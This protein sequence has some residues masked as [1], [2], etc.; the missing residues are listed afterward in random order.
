MAFYLTFDTPLEALDEGIQPLIRALRK[1]GQRT[2]VSCSGLFSDHPYANHTSTYVGI[3]PRDAQSA[4]H[5]KDAVIHIGGFYI[6]RK[7]FYIEEDEEQVD[8]ALYINPGSYSYDDDDMNRMG[9]AYFL[10]RFTALQRGEIEPL[11]EQELWARSQ[12]QET[13]FSDLLQANMKKIIKV[14]IRDDSP[15]IDD[16]FLAKTNVPIQ[17]VQQSTMRVPKSKISPSISVALQAR[18]VDEKYLVWSIRKD[19]EENE[20]HIVPHTPGYRIP[21][22]EDAQTFSTAKEAIQAAYDNEL[23]NQRVES[24]QKHCR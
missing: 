1:E 6:A 10:Q 8:L 7:G 3:F 2:F 20:Y 21:Q 19:K 24:E 11:S 12:Q 16:M 5:L 9:M 22:W 17:Y 18:G 15:A 4:H 13:A 14:P 23:K